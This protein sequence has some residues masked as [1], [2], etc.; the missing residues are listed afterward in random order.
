[1]RLKPWGVMFS[2][3]MHHGIDHECECEADLPFNLQARI[4]LLK[5]FTTEGACQET[6][7]RKARVGI[8]IFECHACFS[9]FWFHLTADVAKFFQENAPQWPK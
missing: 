2:P 8:A 6:N 9:K 3:D 5:G 1:M 7:E 4:P